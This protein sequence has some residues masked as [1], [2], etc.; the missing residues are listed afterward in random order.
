MRSS[1]LA[2]CKVHS[3]EFPYQSDQSLPVWEIVAA[4]FYER[5][6][7][8]RSAGPNIL[9][10][11]GSSQERVDN[12]CVSSQTHFW[13]IY[14]FLLTPPFFS[15]LFH[16]LAVAY[17]GSLSYICLSPYHSAW[18]FSL[19]HSEPRDRH[20]PFSC[21]RASGGRFSNLRDNKQHAAT[22]FLYLWNGCVWM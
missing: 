20:T 8:Q 2:A 5:R 21:A 14:P 12:S 3:C 4:Y 11:N 17:P 19:L 15:S 6:R 9:T 13:Y 1:I 7:P 22:S 18:I 16:F 10:T